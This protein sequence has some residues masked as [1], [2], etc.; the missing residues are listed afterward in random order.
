MKLQKK[1]LS[2]IQAFVEAELPAIRNLLMEYD[3]GVY[4]LFDRY[5]I[6][7]S[8]SKWVASISGTTK[9]FSTLQS[10]ACW[11][12]AHN[13]QQYDIAQKIAHYDAEVDR[14]RTEISLSRQRIS[15]STDSHFRAL[16]DAK[17]S[18]ATYRSTCA[19]QELDKYLL[20]AKY[21]QTKGF[22]NETA[23]PFEK[24]RFKRHS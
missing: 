7:G 21:W 19:R 16:L 10:A 15:K 3:T 22:N 2:K 23:R 20:L 8:T 12:V 6:T 24:T 14:Y 18:E 9:E 4:V 5:R 11:A 17:C 1:N 13:A